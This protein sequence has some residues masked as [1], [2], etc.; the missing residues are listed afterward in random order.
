MHRVRR[1]TP[2]TP[3][4]PHSSQSVH[5]TLQCC[6]DLCTCCG[7]QV[8]PISA[9][10]RAPN[11]CTCC[12]QPYC[13]VHHILHSF[14]Q[15]S[16]NCVLYF[17]LEYLLPG[18]ASQAFLTNCCGH[19]KLRHQNSPLELGWTWRRWDWWLQLAFNPQL[20]LRWELPQQLDAFSGK[21][22]HVIS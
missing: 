19:C 9:M 22:R 17:T 16:T 10:I 13:S 1:L 4:Q 15:V 18:Y 11:L 2:R 20:I 7:P 21:S 14:L 3:L 8:L 5:T 6:A 12:E